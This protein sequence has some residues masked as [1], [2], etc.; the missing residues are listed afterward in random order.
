MGNPI[1]DA[2]DELPVWENF[3]RDIWEQ[4]KVAPE[5]IA[6][7]EKRVADLESKLARCP[8]EGCPYCG[9]LAMRL[10]TSERS[11]SLYGRFGAR[12]ERWRCQECGRSQLQ[13]VYPQSMPRS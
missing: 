1:S 11:H 8:G 10:E 6:A 9:A 13:T 5:R 2:K 12:E 7:L 3:S 4:L